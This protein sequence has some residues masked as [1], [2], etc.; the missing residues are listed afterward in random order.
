MPFLKHSLL[1]MV[2]CV[3][4][5]LICSML[6]VTCK[7]PSSSDDDKKLTVSLTF[8]GPRY[9]GNFYSGFLPSTDWA[10]W[11]ANSSNQHIKTLK[12]NEGVV[13][14]GSE[15]SHPDH[16]PAWLACTGD[17]INDIPDA[18]SIPDRFD[19]ITAASYLLDDFNPDE[20]V[21][22][23]WDFTDAN[24]TTVPE[25]TYYFYAEVGNIQKDSADNADGYTYSVL[26]ENT[27]GTVTYPSGATVDGTPTTNILSCTGTVD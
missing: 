1:T 16:L 22:A 7:A 2:R 19:G 23:S 15:G 20:T 27:A 17:S 8:K 10:V 25:D 9:Q 4:I 6:F 18:D 3:F 26:H 5:T 13:K 14:V 11:I 24:G 12:I 21:T